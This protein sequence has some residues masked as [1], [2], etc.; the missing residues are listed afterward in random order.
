MAGGHRHPGHDAFVGTLE[1]AAAA[2]FKS[3]GARTLR[4]RP[5]VLASRSAWTD[6][7]LQEALRVALR[8][9]KGSLDRGA[10]NGLSSQAMLLNLVGPLV[11]RRHLTPLKAA[12]ERAGVEWPGRRTTPRFEHRD[13]S[14]FVEGGRYPTS[15]DLFLDGGADGHPLAIECKM[16]EDEFGPC[17]AHRSHRCRGANPAVEFS[18][19][20]LQKRP[21]RGAGRRYWSVMEEFGCMTPG[22]RDY[23]GCVMAD[24]H[25]FFREVLFALKKGGAFVLLVDG[26]NPTFEQPGD[27]TKGLFHELRALL[28]PAVQ[29]KVFKV[30]VQDVLREIRAS[31]KHD[32]W[33]G[34]FEKKYGLAPAK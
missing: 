6:N 25:Q 24:H 23:R 20:Y 3:K 5:H 2:Y 29:A 11:S 16:A 30:T 34:E 7:F 12:L 13:A 4:D 8:L 22:V 9:P 14:V 18:I 10:H 1:K 15:I 26:R 19:C 28:P 31:G 17:T 27:R 33:A 21:P 32:D